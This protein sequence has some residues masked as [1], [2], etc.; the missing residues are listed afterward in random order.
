MT[1]NNKIWILGLAIVVYFASMQG[2]AIVKPVY[3]ELATSIYY[4][5]DALSHFLLALFIFINFKKSFVPFVLLGL[6]IN[7][8][9]DEL[10]FNPTKLQLNE[11]VFAILIFSF[12][13]YR[14]IN[15]RRAGKTTTDDID[16]DN[17][18]GYEA[19]N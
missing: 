15:I 2:Y 6:T 4:K 17:N 11:L 14:H 13:I 3:P 9:A 12:G 1:G 8:L 16:C 19:N 10:F 5:G 7:N 18:N